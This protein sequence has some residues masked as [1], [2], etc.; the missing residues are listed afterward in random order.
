ME[1]AVDEVTRLADG[2]LGPFEGSSDDEPL[3]KTRRRCFPRDAAGMKIRGRIDRSECFHTEK[4][5]SA[6]SEA[7]P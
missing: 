2:D 5:S 7:R 6:I 1:S 3:E 4:C